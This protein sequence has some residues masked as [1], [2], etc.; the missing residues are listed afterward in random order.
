MPKKLKYPLLFLAVLVL[1][2]TVSQT[3]FALE[4]DYPTIGG[5]KLDKNSTL[6]DFI[7]Y[8]FYLAVGFAG[9]VGV[10]SIVIAG[11][12]LLASA[13][14][15]ASQGAARE[16]IFGSILGIVL[17]MFS[18]TLLST[19]NPQLIDPNQPALTTTVGAGLY[20]VNSSDNFIVAPP[21][22]A[23]TSNLLEGFNKLVYICK[24]PTNSPDLLVYRYSLPGLDDNDPDADVVTLQC[25]KSTD[26]FGTY[27]YK[28][29]Y[30]Q[31][32]VY[33]FK[34]AGCTG[35]STEVITNTG[36]L[37]KEFERKVTSALIVNGAGDND[38][39]YGFVLTADPNNQGTC[40]EPF[41]NFSAEDQCINVSITGPGCKP[42]NTLPPIDQPNSGV[43]DSLNNKCIQDYTGQYCIEHSDCGGGSDYYCDG[44]SA[45][46]QTVGHCK[47]YT[48][49][50]SCTNV[51]SSCEEPSKCGVDDNGN[52]F[53]G[54]E[55]TGEPCKD[56]N[57]CPLPPD[58]RGG[59][60][61][62]ESHTCEAESTCDP[63][64]EDCIS[65]NNDDDCNIDSGA[66]CDPFAPEPTCSP[67]GVGE[68]SCT[69][70]IDCAGSKCDEFSPTPSCSPNGT[71][72]DCTS[73]TECGGYCDPDT[74]Q[75]V[76]ESCDP[77]LEDCIPCNFSNNNANGGI[78]NPA[79]TPPEPESYCTTTSLFNPYS[80]CSETG[81]SGIKCT[82][83]VTDCNG[84]K[85]YCNFSNNQCTTDKFYFQNG[86]PCLL[87]SPCELPPS[88]GFKCSAPKGGSGGICGPAGTSSYTNDGCSS[89][90]KSGD[91]C[92]V[93]V[94]P[95]PPPPTG[96]MTCNTATKQCVLG[97]PG[98]TCDAQQ[99]STAVA[100]G[101]TCNASTKQCV[102]GLP[103][104][105]CDAQQ[106]STAV[107]GSGM[108]CDTNLKQCVPG[109]PGLTCDPATCFLSNKT[110]ITCDTST[111][112]CVPGLSGTSC[113]AQTCS[114]QIDT[115]T[116]HCLAG[117][118]VPGAVGPQLPWCEFDTDCPQQFT[119]SY[120]C[121]IATN[122]CRLGNNNGG[123]AC[124]SASDCGFSCDIDGQCL[125]GYHGYGYCNP[126]S[127]GCGTGYLHSECN[128]MDHT[129]D[130]VFGPGTDQCT[131]FPDCQ[132]NSNPNFHTICKAST[133]PDISGNRCML[134]ANKRPGVAELDECRL[135]QPCSIIDTGA[136]PFN[137]QN[138]PL[139]SFLGI[140]PFTN[141]GTSLYPENEQA[142]NN[143][144]SIK[145]NLPLVL[146]S[147]AKQGAVLYP[148][149]I[150]SGF[151]GAILA[152]DVPGVTCGDGTCDYP[153]EDSTNCP[154]DCGSGSGGGSG[155]SGSSG[156]GGS[157]GTGN[158]S[159]CEQF[160]ATSI[161]IIKGLN[162]KSAEANNSDF[163]GSGVSI[164]ED[165]GP[166]TQGEPRVQG[167]RL[168]GPKF[169]FIG[170]YYMTENGEYN[171][172]VPGEHFK[173]NGGPDD[174]LT[175]PKY[176]GTDKAAAGKDTCAQ[177]P[178][179]QNSGYCN[180]KTLKC[181]TAYKIPIFS[182]TPCSSVDNNANGTNADCGAPSGWCSETKKCVILPAQKPCELDTECSING[183][184]GECNKEV[185]LLGPGTSPTSGIC[186][187]PN[188]S[189]G[190]ACLA[191]R[192]CDPTG[193]AYPCTRAIEPSGNFLTILYSKNGLPDGAQCYI[194][195]GKIQDLANYDIVDQNRKIFR[196]D[197]FP[198]VP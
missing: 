99:C 13:G 144:V 108:T 106:C 197:I 55:G 7:A 158:T 163:S 94:P 159:Q 192:N 137:N 15:P 102:P 6:P 105:T 180:K 98:L 23:D 178:N 62:T 89:T 191:D 123:V 73:D 190:D 122:Q 154:A 136:L 101:I 189:H 148:A 97:L 68:Q 194:S 115:S 130:L 4:N 19:I 81:T 78:G 167:N 126:S 143:E 92:N 8:F 35:I 31:P 36:T 70:N 155:G 151:N 11:I 1:F 58:N 12:T 90:S 5:I 20:L 32:G 83:G 157:G 164:Y 160:P 61:D 146:A 182:N 140:L 74:Q 21:Y 198:I 2:L 9:I 56:V 183:I 17:L 142:P 195:P 22:Q 95:P 72:A 165:G 149:S 54:P 87:G 186:S 103:G 121:D 131:Y 181:I 196:M 52:A 166:A 124:T 127:G 113:D 47:S 63:E 184:K 188:S 51:G 43:C 75:C 114:G 42:T 135:D 49:L 53:C 168:V 96:G 138:P 175:D 179:T 176:Y 150:L 88:T 117:T 45:E 141:Q 57:D 85:G 27:S 125:A 79:C 139:A 48:E 3:V 153:D 161:Y 14:N 28:T 118:C 39:H 29:A 24:N 91:P 171:N 173:Y 86:Y 128:F 65:C 170:R 120:S 59:Y 44:A 100:G 132:V 50:A 64:T 93:P 46:S 193:A 111:Q 80:Q 84:P 67:Y 147:E 33:L 156:G 41:N 172:G 129:C 185:Q 104:L 77:A 82:P 169:A 112:K 134:V 34:G 16:R 110:G 60:C 162:S 152:E 76:Y 25:G 119:T 10:L 18:I 116:S 177:L 30:K 66:H 187:F 107:V 26:I 145:N 109:L 37:P 69:N 133:D 40:S 38:P 71:G 174:L